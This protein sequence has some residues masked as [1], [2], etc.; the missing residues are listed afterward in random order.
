MDRARVFHDRADAGKALAVAVA[1]RAL[2][3]PLV[4]GL[5]RGGVPVAFEVARA[6]SAD[7]DVLVVR[8]LG[9]PDQPE[10]AFG[11]IASG[12]VRVFNA[13]VM[14]MLPGLK[15]QAVE[16][17]L[18]RE[19]SEL[20]RRE[21]AFRGERRYLDF[22]DR[23]ILLVDDGMA[24][25]ATMHAAVQAVRQSGPRRVLVAVPTA[26]PEALKR[27]FGDADEIICLD[28][29]SPYFSVG[30]YYERFDQTTDQEVRNLL[31]RAWRDGAS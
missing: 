7:L 20:T 14:Q 28:S 27:L 6:I 29:P 31:H 24:T 21:A 19:S 2:H 5:P 30:S 11:A 9:V 13:D 17:I 26:S 18:A 1:D 15:D 12:G 25:G 3:R 16:R 23:D 10:L 4:L 8:K 22:T